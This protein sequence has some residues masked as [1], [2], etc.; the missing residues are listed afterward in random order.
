MAALVVTLFL[1]PAIA[2]QVSVEFDDSID[3]K[4][5]QTYVVDDAE[6]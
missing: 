5:Y 2:A 1:L 3:F 6:I 4:D